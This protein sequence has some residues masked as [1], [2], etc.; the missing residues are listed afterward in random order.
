MFDNRFVC[1][2]DWLFCYDEWEWR[3]RTLCLYNRQKSHLII[4]GGIFI[5]L[6]MEFTTSLQR[7]YPGT[8]IENLS[9]G[10]LW[11]PDIYR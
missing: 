6:Y 1:V 8:S 10:L 2:D 9:L 11:Q 4:S 5:L 3:Y 7:P